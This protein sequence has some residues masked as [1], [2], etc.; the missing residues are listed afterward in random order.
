MRLKFGYRQVQLNT[1]KG[2]LVPY[3][4][5]STPINSAD[6]LSS[7]EFMQLQWQL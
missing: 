3:E 5:E 1:V 4:F 7:N 2:H 6:I